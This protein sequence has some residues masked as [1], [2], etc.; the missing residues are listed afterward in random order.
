MQ[1]PTARG[2][3]GAALAVGA[4]AAALFWPR[5][6]SDG[7]LALDV[8]G[9][10]SGGFSIPSP[11]P[12]KEGWFRLVRSQLSS[13]IP[14]LTE[15]DRARLAMAILEEAEAAGL[16]PLF[17]L[18]VIEVES[19]FDP[20]ARSLRGAMGLMQLRPSTLRS[21][22]R[23]ARLSDG[24]A[25]DP[26]TNVRGGVRYY[27]RLL[28]IFK[29]QDAALMAYNAGPRRISGYLKKG[30]VPERF[31][32]YPRRVRQ[33]V[34]RLRRGLSLGGPDAVAEMV[35]APGRLE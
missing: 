12:G 4:L 18:A 16:D 31:R 28:R 10:E 6:L 32:D 19:A 24:D 11:P 23:R 29:S 17:V 27:R 34:R 9:P 2:C 30:Q 22:L 35:P 20:G 7:Q 21:E 1:T 13:R 5:P 33:E 3:A 15:R 14:G 8:D 26:V 25:R